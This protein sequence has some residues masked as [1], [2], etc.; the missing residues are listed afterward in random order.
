MKTEL[1]IILDTSLLPPNFLSKNQN[2]ELFER[3]NL[4]DQEFEINSIWDFTNK[5]I[6]NTQFEHLLWLNP[7]IDS[8]TKKNYI[9][10]YWEIG[11]NINS[12][13]AKRNADNNIAW[14]AAF[15]SYIMRKSGAGDQFPYSSNHAHYISEGKRDT[16]DNLFWTYKISERKPQKGDLVCNNRDF[17]NVNY[18]NVERGGSTHCDI[19]MEVTKSEAI[20]IGGNKGKGEVKEA[21]LYLDQNG[22]IDV[23]RNRTVKNGKVERE[24]FAII[25]IF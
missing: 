15:I 11:L 20:V 25:S 9:K 12:A 3:K 8:T 6:K 17:S 4:Y 16:L 23:K 10:G 1:D 24:H 14:S 18:D 2:N 22:F 13:Q 19:V 7:K 21:K 5:V